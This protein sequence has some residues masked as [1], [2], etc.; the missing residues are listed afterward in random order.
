MKKGKLL[1]WLLIFSFIIG[2]LPIKR[3]DAATNPFE[4]DKLRIMSLDAGRKYFSPENIKKII[5]K[6]SAKNFTHLHL[7]L[8][9]DGMRFILDDMSVSTS[10]KKY[11]SEEIK[12][13]IKL[14]N[15]NYANRH[16][17]VEDADSVIT[18][19]EMDEIFEY[20]KSKNISIIPAINSPGHMDAILD[21]AE[22][23]GISDAHYVR[24][25]WLG[26]KKS[27]TTLNI[28][29]DE[30]V[31]FSKALIKKYV[32]YFNEK[33]IEIFNIGFDEF[34]ND[35]FQVPGWDKII[36]NGQYQ[37]VA[38]YANELVK[39]ISSKN[40]RPMAFN[41][42]IYYND[43]TSYP[44]DKN[45]IIAYWTKGWGGFYVGKSTTHIAQ[46]HD[47]LNV[48]DSWYYVL[49]REN[50]G[51]YNRQ[52][53]LN[54][55]KEAS[56]KY[57]KNVGIQV[58]TIGS[59]ISFWC[60]NPE[61]PYEEAKLDEWINTFVENNKDVFED[62]DNTPIA[63][64]KSKLSELLS[65]YKVKLEDKSYKVP[66]DVAKENERKYNISKEIFDNEK[67]TEFQVEKAV[68]EMTAVLEEIEKYKQEEIVDPIY[69]E[70]P[71][72]AF[73]NP[74]LNAGS[75]YKQPKEG[76]ELYQPS[77]YPATNLFDK[78]DDTFVWFD[79]S[80]GGQEIG[81]KVGVDL[82]QVYKLGKFRAVMGGSSSGD[83]WTK[84]QVKYSVDGK[85]WKSQ[86][87]IFE[88]TEAKKTISF[89]FNNV[90]ARYVVLENREP[91]SN[92]LQV[93]D[94]VVETSEAGASEET[95]NKLSEKIKEAESIDLSDKTEGT[96]S[97]L[98]N[99]IEEAKN[100]D[101]DANEEVV[102]AMISRLDN[103]IKSLRKIG[104]KVQVDIFPK[105]KEIKTNGE[106]I[107]LGNSVNVV[108]S[109]DFDT[110][111]YNLL[112]KVLNDKHVKINE[113]ENK[114]DYTFYLLEDNSL[115]GVNDSF[116]DLQLQDLKDKKNN[117][118]ELHSL[119]D[120]TVIHSKDDKGSFY[121]VKTLEQILSGND[122]VKADIV[123]YPSMEH[124]GT[125][126]GFYSYKK[127]DWSV[128]ERI[129]Q[130]KFYGDNKLNTYIYA[131]KHDPYHGDNWRT[132]YP[133]A[134]LDKL[135]QVANEA[136]LN[137]VD[138]VYGIAPGKS[139]NAGLE[140]DIDT[141]IAKLT[142]LYDAGIR[143]FAVFFDDI[144]SNDGKAHATILNKVNERFINKKEG[145]GKLITVPK[146]Y[147]T[148]DMTK[149]ESSIK[150]MDDFINTLSKDIFVMWT[151]NVVV[152]DGISNEDAKWINGKFGDM[153]AVWHNYPV[154]DYQIE[155][156]ALGPIVDMGDEIH[157]YINYFTLN[158]MEYAE[159]SKISIGT[160]AD[161]MWNNEQYNPDR[162]WKKVSENL[163]G[164]LAQD[165]L[166]FANHSTRMN[167]SIGSSGRK[168]APELNELIDKYW[169]SYG[170]KEFDT[171]SATLKVEFEKIIKSCDALLNNLEP[172][173]LRYAQD[174][175]EKLKLLAQQSIN[176]LELHKKVINKEDASDLRETI[177][178]SGYASGKEISETTLVKF[179][180][181]ILSFTPNPKA[182]FALSKNLAKV[183]ETITITNLSSRVS[184]EF[185]WSIKGA[186]IVSNN[187]KEVTIKYPKEGIYD[188]KLIAK[189]ELGEDVKLI[190]N[191]V[192]VS[193]TIS[194]SKF[195][196]IALNKNTKIS[197]RCAFS[198]D[199]K[200]AVD[201]SLK[202]KWCGANYVGNEYIIV[203]LA[204]ESLIKGFKLHHAHAGGE[205]PGMNTSAYEI[206][207]SNDGSE[208]TKVIEVKNNESDVTEHSIPLQKAKYAKLVV[209]RPN[210]ADN[211]R[212]SRIY[213]FE[214]F[215]TSENPDLPQKFD[216]EVD[217]TNLQFTILEAKKYEQLKDEYDENSFNNLL[218]ALQDAQKALDTNEIDQMKI[219]EQTNSLLEA[220]KQLKKA[221]QKP[222]DPEE[223]KDPEDPE[224]PIEDPKDPEEPIEEPE[225]RHGWEQQN[226]KWIYFDHGK[227]AI[228]EWKWIKNAWKFFNSKGESMAQ[229]YH[230]NGMIWLSLEGPNTRYKK[231]WWTNPENGY[232]YFFRLSSGTMVKGKQFI[233]GN[234]RFFRK[235]GTLATGWQKLP[236]GWMYFRTGTGTQAYGWQWIDGVWRYLRPNTG[237]RASGKQWIDGRWYNFTWDGK[238]IGRR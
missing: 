41:D 196:N 175:I 55:M 13:G 170:T 52:N 61:K 104:E 220:I 112:V 39:Y 202:T 58:P 127:G 73:T 168:E 92:W 31:E 231:G 93:S 140:S 162:A 54:K 155:K 35:A 158:P 27:I 142:Q 156:L 110:T 210:Q 37:K 137:K 205:T 213:E 103:A 224:E 165:M 187:G 154:T 147:N 50:D 30:M 193:D 164:D 72:E 229:F 119:D 88:Q 130:M 118:Y 160:G 206:Y 190:E 53:A 173:Y 121:A 63:K 7:L 2:F 215:G 208:Y 20:A 66:S 44:F 97:N 34:A 115:D 129:S 221:E 124:R 217:K 230:E 64:D 6:L 65:N 46:G 177:A 42:G 133:K 145:V 166:V 194:Q 198:E 71:I 209:T 226:G 185:E 57:D 23:V 188:I 108:K 132:L 105:V 228:S 153:T 184:K 91:M 143:H 152:A 117:A 10:N 136:K 223:P 135:V 200:Y 183:N 234:W 60:D 68:E 181:D 74:I 123:D 48:N 87:P 197:S 79:T 40:I 144:N 17:L 180:K 218:K 237:T 56:F 167:G 126:E 77:Q 95:L 204:N 80:K 232:T 100:I 84:Y 82:G 78:K 139:I 47:V 212:A 69:P 141:L 99:T 81:D 227:Q 235:S 32:D 102:K 203:D 70:K 111:A 5:D 15:Q 14:G 128:E 45:I 178:N 83:H 36:A 38:D 9:N 146:Q 148:F 18:Q 25:D 189:N 216:S 76:F 4:S 89:I 174:N 238:L 107:N 67:A 122:I 214:V 114:E 26:E 182:D 172:K 157:K 192:T 62:K 51:G 116:K 134:E 169:E 211:D 151:G 94:F 201:G 207:L 109:E 96:K 120:K 29:N 233:S 113:K 159:L 149:N 236:L 86:G 101:K 85:I 43:N 163:F 171:L 161:F 11:D 33:G 49:G 21:A 16:N 19:K 195:D 24:K 125:I 179:I 22:S 106:T 219:D 191:A 186:E 28:L 150:Y 138:F 131:P 176:S 3:V 75:I 222:E 90:N 8:G 12:K 225:N 199:G 59:M 1:S 98:I